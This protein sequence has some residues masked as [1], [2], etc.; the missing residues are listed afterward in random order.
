[1]AVKRE[2]GTGSGTLGM[3]VVVAVMAVVGCRKAP[4]ERGGPGGAAH[5][6]DVVEPEA[7][8]RV[9]MLVRV[10]FSAI[11]QPILEMM[12]PSMLRDLTK[13]CSVDLG[14]DLGHIEAEI[15]GQVQYRLSADGAV[16]RQQV[17]CVLDPVLDSVKRGKPRVTARAGGGLDISTPDMPV[18]S[19][20]RAVLD[21][22]MAEAPKGSM[23][24][25]ALRGSD[26]GKLLDILLWLGFTDGQLRIRY[27]SRD[28]A[29]KAKQRLE[30]AS[31]AA[32]T[33]SGQNVRI[34]DREL[35]I[36]G[37][38]LPMTMALGP[39]VMETYQTATD[40][41]APAVLARED[42][43]YVKGPFL[44]EIVTGDVLVYKCT[45]TAWCVG[46]VRARGGERGFDPTAKADITVPAGHLLM[47]GDSD[48][49][50]TP[51]YAG[52]F[53]ESAVSGR[54]I[55]VWWSVDQAGQTRWDRIWKLIE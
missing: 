20:L 49:V 27:V 10:D 26:H 48:K 8:A 29:E 44:R 11:P 53:P 45:E 2:T 28:E 7:G 32:A 23:V 39:G 13:T 33:L 54:A 24:V 15:A 38:T 3:V 19:G 16:T 37:P 46:R 35:V 36:S 4:R 9:Q 6:R 1:M 34:E 30:G 51:P 31:N 50:G 52:V 17:A 14:R 18:H 55:I 43:Y 40:L 21:R 47:V 22:R 25:M 41:M 42:F 5:S 12:L